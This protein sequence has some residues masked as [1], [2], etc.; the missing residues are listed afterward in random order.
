[1][2]LGVTSKTRTLPDLSYMVEE[3]IRRRMENVTGV[4]TVNIN[5]SSTRE[6]Q[7]EPDVAK[8]RARRIGVDQLLAALRNDNIDAPVGN[9]T[10]GQN[11]KSVRVDARFKQ[12]SDFANLVVAAAMVC[13]CGWAMSPPSWM[14]A[15]SKRALP[16]LMGCVRSASTCSRYAAA[17][18]SRLASASRLRLTV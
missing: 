6:I 3:V 8:L 5:G 14:A 7:I 17:T 18:R 10:I 11:D 16:A 4:A 13:R 12:V 1:M 2:S 9:I 15:R